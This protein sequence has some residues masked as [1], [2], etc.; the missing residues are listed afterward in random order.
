[1]PDSEVLIRL[2]S[3]A[4]KEYLIKTA[5]L[6]TGVIVGANLLEMTPGATVSLA[7]RFSS[8]ERKFAIDPL[9]YVFALD[10]NYIISEKTNKKTG[11]VTREMKKSFQKLCTSFGGPFQQK[12]LQ[13]RKSLMPTD[14]GSAKA[15]SDLA[16]CVLSYQLDR[17]KAICAA[18][19]QLKDFADQA[20]PS[21]VFS[22]YFYI[23]GENENLS[24]E[25]ETLCL[26]AI[27]EFGSLPSPVPKYAVICIARRI[28]RDRDRLLRLIRDVAA[29]G[30]QGC[31]FWVSNFKEEDITESEL[32]NLDL[33]VRA[34][35]S[36]TFKLFN[37]HGGFLSALLSKHGLN[38]FSHSIG[39]GESKDVF[40]VSGGALP[41]V[42]YHYPPLHVKASVP[43]IDRAFSTLGISTA[44]DFHRLVC[45]CTLCVGTL[46]GNLRNFRKFG[47]LVLKAGN[48]RE[49]QTAES[50][51]RCRFHYLLSRKKELDLVNGLTIE[52][53]KSSLGAAVSEYGRLPISIRLRERS[54]PLKAWISQF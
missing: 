27:K 31:W 5:N 36:D 15:I 21:F 16:T 41:T 44:A 38:G 12:A 54:F 33:F 46:R 47:E 24:Y 11:T 2:G 42:I 45:D 29:S 23:P 48:T 3:H 53:L 19:P 50:A 6:F 25:W 22:P 30:C 32:I 40:P 35:S 49:S 39:Y 34:G 7:W 9:T 10:Q 1:M 26:A 20:L 4:E 51:K 37:L 28:L 43:D 8:L 52:Q 18:D 14:F 17:M 13:Q